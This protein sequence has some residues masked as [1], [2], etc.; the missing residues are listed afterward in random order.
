MM[1]LT[2]AGNSNSI[3][4]VF[5][6]ELEKMKRTRTGKFSLNS[7]KNP[8]SSQVWFNEKSAR[9]DNN[10][11]CEKKKAKENVGGERVKDDM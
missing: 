1:V 9:K 6:A 2:R 10:G 5:F 7:N 8:S 3:N 4:P 11:K